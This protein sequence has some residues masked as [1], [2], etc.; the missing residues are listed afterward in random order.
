MLVGLSPQQITGLKRISSHL[1]RECIRLRHYLF[2]FSFRTAGTQFL[3]SR[4]RF[5][6]LV[7]AP[8]KGMLS[9]L[10]FGRLYL[11]DAFFGGGARRMHRHMRPARLLL[12]IAVT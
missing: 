7:G 11:A 1:L 5:L 8:S 6:A 12:S 9:P 4:D 10:P 2:L 3:K